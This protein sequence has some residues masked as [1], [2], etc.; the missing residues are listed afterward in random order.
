L[1]V[2]LALDSTNNLYVADAF[3]NRILKFAPVK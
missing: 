2:G 3:N 1:P